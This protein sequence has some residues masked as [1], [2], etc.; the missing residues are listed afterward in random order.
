MFFYEYEPVKYSIY[1]MDVSFGD[2]IEKFRNFGGHM[3]WLLISI[4]KKN[5]LI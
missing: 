4:S 5:Y 3:L 1:I 2:F